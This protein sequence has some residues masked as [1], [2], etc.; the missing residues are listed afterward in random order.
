MEGSGLSEEELFELFDLKKP[1][2]REVNVDRVA[3]VSADTVSQPDRDALDVDAWPII[4][5]TELSLRS[6][7]RSTFAS[8]YGLRAGERVYEH[9]GPDEAVKIK[10]RISETRKRYL[11]A[12]DFTPSENPL[13]YLY[14]QQLVELISREW[15]LF[16][17]VFGEKSFLMNK[18]KD[19][20]GVRN[21]EAHFRNIPQ[22]ERMRAYVAC[23]DILAKVRTRTEVAKESGIGNKG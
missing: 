4:R 6:S 8:T 20:A 15:A 21:D 22:V 3:S 2:G 12:P 11:T 10:A 16:K 9:L 23:S 17:S 19:I 14:L 7:I 1:P 13:D 18:V 5:E